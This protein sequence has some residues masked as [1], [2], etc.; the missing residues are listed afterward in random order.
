MTLQRSKYIKIDDNIN[1]FDSEDEANINIS[2]AF[3][4]T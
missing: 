2:L 4:K 1:N 3:A